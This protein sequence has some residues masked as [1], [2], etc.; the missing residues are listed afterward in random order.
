MKLSL[1]VLIPSLLV[2]ACGVTAPH[3]SEGY[4]D[5]D[6]LGFSDTDTT[7]HNVKE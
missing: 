5:L 6:S 7:R 2:G 1:L 4:A 3:S